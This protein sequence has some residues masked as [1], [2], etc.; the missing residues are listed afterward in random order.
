M[1]IHGLF[2]YFFSATILKPVQFLLHLPDTGPQLAYFALLSEDPWPTFPIVEWVQKSSYHHLIDCKQNSHQFQIRKSRSSQE[3]EAPSSPEVHK[4]PSSTPMSPTTST[5]EVCFHL[6]PVNKRLEPS[7]HR[8]SP[9]FDSAMY[10]HQTWASIIIQIQYIALIFRPSRWCFFM[11]RIDPRGDAFSC[12]EFSMLGKSVNQSTII[13][14]MRDQSNF[15]SLPQNK[16]AQ[17]CSSRT[18]K[19]MHWHIYV[20]ESESVNL[21]KDKDLLER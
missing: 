3:E 15:S 16:E 17:V 12:V 2:F 18:H 4:H 8:P 20:V 19:K 9:T 1:R 21:L 6:T 10:A 13:S 5:P 7:R 14:D 11:S